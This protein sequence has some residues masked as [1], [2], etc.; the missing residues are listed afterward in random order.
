MKKKY[1][2]S[3]SNGSFLGVLGLLMLLFMIPGLGWWILAII[4]YDALKK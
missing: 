1:E 2:T 4:V 3:N